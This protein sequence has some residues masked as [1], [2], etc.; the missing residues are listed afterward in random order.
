MKISGE[1]IRGMIKEEVEKVLAKSEAVLPGRT[2]ENPE[3]HEPRDTLLGALE[4]LMYKLEA[5][6]RKE[7]HKNTQ[8]LLQNQPDIYAAAAE[9]IN[10]ITGYFN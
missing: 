3:D 8:Y 9:A 2:G 6:P 1:Q 5:V 4:I 7:W 10:K